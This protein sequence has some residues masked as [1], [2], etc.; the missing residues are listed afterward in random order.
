MVTDTDVRL[1]F[2]RVN[3]WKFPN[4]VK[5]IAII[6]VPKNY[7]AKYLNDHCLVPLTYIIM[8]CF[9]SGFISNNDETDHRKEIDSLVTWCKDNNLSLNVSKMKEL[10]INFRKQS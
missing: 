2:L 7:Q 4:Y 1:A 8:K 9:E 10:V 5:K 3:P 6:P